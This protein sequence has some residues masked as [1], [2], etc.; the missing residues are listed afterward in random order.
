[1]DVSKKHVVLVLVVGFCLLATMVAAQ[2]PGELKPVSAEPTGKLPLMVIP[3]GP[4][5]LATPAGSSATPLVLPADFFF[6]G[7]DPLR[8]GVLLE[9]EAIG[10]RPVRKDGFEWMFAEVVES[11]GDGGPDLTVPYDTIMVQYQNAILPRIGSQV[12]VDLKLITVRARSVGPVEVTGTETRYY[13][14]AVEITPYHQGE[15][16]SETMG[17]M[18]FTRDGLGS[19]HFSAEV[20]GWARF[21]FTPLG[22]GETVI[23]DYDE[24]LTMPTVADT[25]FLIPALDPAIG[26]GRATIAAKCCC[27]GHMCALRTHGQ[28]DCTHCGC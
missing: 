27:L 23:Y 28:E 12:T 17:S 16:R 14:L 7:S 26:V 25:P 22:P 9:G 3:G 20:F 6:D 8:E 24:L 1:M 10:P 11:G 5:F 2:H 19:G 18:T 4:H 21:I 15:G 13:D